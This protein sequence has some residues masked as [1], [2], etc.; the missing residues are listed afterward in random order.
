[1]PKEA[2]KILDKAERK[3]P[4]EAYIALTKADAYHSLKMNDDVFLE[5]KKAFANGALPVGVKI[6]TIY[7]I[8]Q[9]YDERTSL[10]MVEELS[11]TL[12][13]RHPEQADAQAVYGDILLQMR[14]YDDAHAAFLKALSS[15]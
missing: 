1:E 3:F 7:N 15:N 8:L 5:L 4:D 2:L 14:R 12:V 9:Q 6:R 10:Y 11:K 13:E